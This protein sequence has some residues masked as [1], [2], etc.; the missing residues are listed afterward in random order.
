MS[1]K[2]KIIFSFLFIFSLILSACH[3]YEEDTRRSILTPKDRFARTWVLESFE[4]DG[5]T[6][7]LTSDEQY[8][9]QFKKNTNYIKS[10][11]IG[12]QDSILEYGFWNLNDSK[13]NLKMLIYDSITP[14]ETEIIKLSNKEFK[15]RDLEGVSK[16]TYKYIVQ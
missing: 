13:T 6:T 7:T 9:L 3:K 14:I 1:K 4:K 2:V 16:T 15:I 11:I 10:R 5:V 12:G 8:S